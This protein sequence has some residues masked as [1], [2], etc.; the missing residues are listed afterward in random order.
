MLSMNVR[1]VAKLKLDHSAWSLH[2]Q[3]YSL[4]HFLVEK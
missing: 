1:A 3:P 4:Q 2:I